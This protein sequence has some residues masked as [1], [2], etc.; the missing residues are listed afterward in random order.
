M[1]LR[2]GPRAIVLDLAHPR[3]VAVVRSLARAGVEVFG[4]DHRPDATGLFSRYLSRRFRLDARHGYDAELARVLDGL[5]ADGRGGLLI[6][7]ADAPNVFV[8]RNQDTLGRHFALCSPSW[9]A[10][11]LCMDR[12]ASYALAAELGIRAPECHAPK[13]V[14]ELD[15]LLPQLD[16]E[17]ADY[18]LK[19]RVWDAPADV[20]RNRYTLAP[21]QD[22]AS[23][24]RAWCEIDARSQLA[25]TVERIVSGESDDCIGVSLALDPDGEPLIA[26]CIKRLHMY[27]YARGGRYQHPYL[28]GANVYCESIHDP[29]AL[30]AA[31]ALARRAGIVGAITVE[32]RREPESR[33]LTFI[34]FDPRVIRSTSLASRLGMDV[35]L[36]LYR[37]FALRERVTPRDYPDGV[38]WMWISQYVAAL[39]QNASLGSAA[40]E[41]MRLLGMLPTVRAFAYLS[42]RD[43]LPFG[44][45][46]VDQVPLAKRA[47][48]WTMRRLLRPGAA[49][50]LGPG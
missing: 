1:S 25:P 37:C 31:V 4:V 22:P 11:E 26:Y 14:D 9:P 20:A 6:P 27:A 19:T 28:M 8:A 3:A 21:P 45:S 36:A 33:E 46:L 39:R 13:N 23:F 35:P 34:K 18:V 29:E 44:K 16:F 7:T 17:H 50:A 48:R 12:T 15:Q 38:R 47:L 41:S 42:A 43:P 24:R 32:F 10:L 40:T 5:A 49:R 2:P 30:E